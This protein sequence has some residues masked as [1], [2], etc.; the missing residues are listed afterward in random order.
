[1]KTDHLSRLR[2]HQIDGLVEGL[3]VALWYVD[4]ED[5]PTVYHA[6]ETV[7]DLLTDYRD[8]RGGNGGGT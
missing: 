8:K 2:N 5:E 4:R 3:S 7:I 6:V 1:M